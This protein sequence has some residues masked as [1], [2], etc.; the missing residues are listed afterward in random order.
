MGKGTRRDV[1]LERRWRELVVDQERS[2]SSDQPQAP[3]PE[4]MKVSV[5]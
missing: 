5:S 2:G 4:L 3:L 1:E